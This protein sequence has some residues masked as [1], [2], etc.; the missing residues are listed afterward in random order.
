MKIS[1]RSHGTIDKIPFLGVKRSL[2][3]KEEKTGAEVKKQD[4]FF[5][6]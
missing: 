6:N 1:A 5:L 4:T 2:G 3:E